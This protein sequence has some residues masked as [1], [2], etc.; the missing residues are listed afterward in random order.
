[1]AVITPIGIEI[2]AETRVTAM[3]AIISGKMPKSGGLEVGYQYLPKIKSVIVTFLKIG[4][5]SMNKK[6]IIMKRIAMEAKA[7]LKKKMRTDLSVLWRA[8]VIGFSKSSYKFFGCK[9][10]MFPRVVHK[11]PGEQSFCN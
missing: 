5:P 8:F 2:T 9:K 4:M 1:M 6:I 3:E 7:T 11:R 10:T